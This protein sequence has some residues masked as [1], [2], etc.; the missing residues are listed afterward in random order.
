MPQPR[1]AIPTQPCAP[2]GV[3]VDYLKYGWEV[4]SANLVGWIIFSLVFGCVVSFTF[5]IG[6]VLT[7]NALRATRKAIASGAAPDL[8]DLFQFDDI[9][10]DAVVMVLMGVANAAGMVVCGFGTLVTLPLFFFAQFLVSDGSFDA[11]NSMKASME[12]GKGNLVGHLVQLL[13]MSVVI[14]LLGTLTMGFGYLVGTPVLLVAFEKYYQDSRS[15]VLAVAQAA[16]IPMK[17]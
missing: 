1:G 4:V 9:A 12:H 8:G 6:M 16:Q 14:S 11:M 13:I 7:P 2:I 5:G 3:S 17:G 10:D 15:D